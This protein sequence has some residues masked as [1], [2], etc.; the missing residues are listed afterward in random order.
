MFPGFNWVLNLKT[1]MKGNDCKDCQGKCSISLP[2]ILCK[3]F[4][5]CHMCFIATVK[6]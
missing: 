5:K 4:E 1:G 6:N 2:F 3:A